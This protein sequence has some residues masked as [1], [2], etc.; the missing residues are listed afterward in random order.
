M[1]TTEGMWLL[2]LVCGVGLGLVA[3]TL[4]PGAGL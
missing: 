2:W 3:S 4:L 1:I